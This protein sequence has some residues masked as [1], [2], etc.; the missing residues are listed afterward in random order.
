MLLNE[1]G[2]K[3]RLIGK[4]NGGMKWTEKNSHPM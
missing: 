3:C 1:M 2:I 4:E